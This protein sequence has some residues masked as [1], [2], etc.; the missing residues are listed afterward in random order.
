MV[1]VMKI[2]RKR[3]KWSLF[4]I[5]RYPKIAKDFSCYAEKNGLTYCNNWDNEN[6][7]G[8]WNPSYSEH[9][10]RFRWGQ[11]ILIHAVINDVCLKANFGYFTL[12]SNLGYLAP[13]GQ[14]FMVAK[15]FIG[16]AWMQ[17]EVVLTKTFVW[18][19]WKCMLSMATH[20]GFEN[21]GMPTKVLISQLSLILDY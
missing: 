13:Q 10:F 14:F 20:S 5:Y 1:N 21:G 15:L 19:M 3:S 18:A 9:N 16:T 17:N 4:I 11:P 12:A 7:V 8:M 6:I 2:P